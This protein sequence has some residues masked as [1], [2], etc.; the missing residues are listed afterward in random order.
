MSGRPTVREAERLGGHRMTREANA[1]TSKGDGKPG[2]EDQPFRWS[3]RI[4]GRIPG[5][6]PGPERVPT[7][8]G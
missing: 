6:M 3:S 4:T 8:V 5:V 2:H 1:G 7:R